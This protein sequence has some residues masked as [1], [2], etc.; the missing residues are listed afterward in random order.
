MCE[1]E[2]SY[3]HR[4][5]DKYVLQNDRIMKGTKVPK[6]CAED[7]KREALGEVSSRQKEERLEDATI[8]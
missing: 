4:F 5:L 1:E 7:K 8:Y 3:V 2:V 6:D